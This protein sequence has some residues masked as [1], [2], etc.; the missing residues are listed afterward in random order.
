[1]A[2]IIVESPT[3]ART[4]NRI[5]KGKDYYVFATLGHIR[6]LPSEKIA[7]DYTKNF[8]PDYKTLKGREKVVAQLKKLA[9]KNDEI[10]LASDL[11]REG[12]SIS[13]HIAY[14]LGFIKEDWPDFS[15]STKKKKLKRIV[16]HEITQ[17]A[18]DEALSNPG[19]LRPALV[20]AQQ[21]RRILDRIVG[22]EL[23][24]LLWKKTGKNWL[25]AGRVQTVALRLVVERE[26]E[27]EAFN[28][29]NYFQ[30]FGEFNPTHVILG[31][32]KT[33][34]PESQEDP[35]QARMT[36][37][38]LRAKLIEK[39]GVAY[40]QTFTLKLFDGEYQYTKGTINKDQVAPLSA[41]LNKDKYEISEIKEDIV[42]RYPPPP[43]TTS[44]LQ[45]DAFNQFG[46]PAKM[47]MRLA[48][49]LYEKGYISYHRTD[50]FNLST[51]FVFAAKRYIEETHGAKYALEKPRGFRNRSK[52]AQE[53]HEAIRPT[54][55][56]KD[57]KEIFADKNLTA[58]HKKIYDLIFRRAVATQMKEA[59]VKQIKIHIKSKKGYV[60]EAESVQVLFDGFLK[61]LNPNYAQNHMQK[62][63]LKLG[64]PMKLLSLEEKENE[65]KPP[66]RYT[67]ASLIKTLEEKGIGRPST[68]APIISLIQEKLYIIRD[69]RYFT[70]TPLGTGISDYLSTA[71]PTLFDI[72]FTAS[73]EE[74]LDE[75]A[76]G[77]KDLVGTL[78]EFFTPFKETLE[79]QKDTKDTIEF[80]EEPSEPCPTCGKPLTMRFSK[81]GRFMACSGYPS[82]KYTK[83]ILKEVPGKICPKDGGKIVVRYTRS[84][85][86]FFGC[87]N[88]PKCTFAAFTFNELK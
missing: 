11:D 73:M 46:Y 15:I 47:T 53:A 81:F 12:E 68:Y 71:F 43:F 69:G 24:P 13:Y 65:T 9:E 3:K 29:E 77:E 28:K 62:I 54:R 58:N 33:T 64:E 32:S 76:A 35:G 41:E 1:M 18:L 17:K 57:T 59:E 74:G 72:N 14:I 19:E 60:F 75:I 49:N 86:R 50:S 66:Y 20:K 79:K 26:K 25:S 39:D 61:V 67:E 4:F 48:Q 8:Q 56:D 37:D 63:S 31:R 82:C 80:K 78:K 30:I 5:L 36:T 52:M 10:I 27:I 70:P 2:L 85:R 7:I 34:T 84:K 88:Y 87:E 83:S 40:E 45:Q 6:D 42:S 44:L 16:F 51:Q 38:R 22:Y 55:L 23:S 21:A